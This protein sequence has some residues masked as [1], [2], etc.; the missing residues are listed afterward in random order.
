MNCLLKCGNCSCF[1]FYWEQCHHLM[2]IAHVSVF[3]DSRYMCNLL[4][5]VDPVPYDYIVQKWTYDCLIYYYF[6]NTIIRN[7][8]SFV[9]KYSKSITETSR[10]RKPYLYTIYIQ[11]PIL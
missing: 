4:R 1:F 7:T 8:I 3:V 2:V 5:N 9:A 11:E 10:I 6:L